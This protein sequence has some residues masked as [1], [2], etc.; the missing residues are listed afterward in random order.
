[1]RQRPLAV[2]QQRGTFIRMPARAAKGPQ[3]M[4]NI[5]EWA[6]PAPGD[7]SARHGTCCCVGSWPAKQSTRSVQRLAPTAGQLSKLSKSAKSS[8]PC[9][10]G[11][12][13]PGQAGVL[14]REHHS[15]S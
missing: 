15:T 3:K 8:T 9:M 5:P 6:A 2:Q 4:S 12:D 10:Q 13:K 14:P 1:M 11:V 7:S